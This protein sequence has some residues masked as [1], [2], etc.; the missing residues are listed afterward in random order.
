MNRGRG[1]LHLPHEGRPRL[2]ELVSK[3]NHIHYDT[4]YLFCYI[5]DSRIGLI[6]GIEQMHVQQE[7]YM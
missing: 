4:K 5:H 2:Y 7:E 1:E 6:G 3:E